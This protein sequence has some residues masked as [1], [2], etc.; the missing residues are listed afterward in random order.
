MS[1]LIKVL[2]VDDHDLVREG[3]RAILGLE[4]EFILVGEAKDGEDAVRK[5]ETLV[6]DVI[7]MDLEM[8]RMGG[9]QAIHII[10]QRNPTAR[11]LVLT[12]FSDDDKVFAAIEEGAL[13]YMLKDTNSETLVQAIR[14]VYHNGPSLHPKIQSKLMKGYVHK[15]EI[16]VTTEPLSHREK[17]I[18]EALARGLSNQAIADQ[19]GI[20]ELTV[21]SH[22]SSIL[23]KLNLE[24]RVQAAL[25]ALRQ[26]LVKLGP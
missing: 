15:K 7:L 24:N 6:P 17:E 8:P 19:L 4:P 13:G 14:I 21:R 12:S 5:A 9:I 1:E 16:A 2:I 20:S 3:L 22:V 26:G 23:G 25:Y 18:L 10:R 11:I